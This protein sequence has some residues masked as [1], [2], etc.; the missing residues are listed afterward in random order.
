MRQYNG[1]CTFNAFLDRDRNINIFELNKSFPKK[2][3]QNCPVGIWELS[4]YLSG[5]VNNQC[6]V[7]WPNAT[8]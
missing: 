5:S 8:R 2:R 3:P 1:L 4:Q 7:R 6:G